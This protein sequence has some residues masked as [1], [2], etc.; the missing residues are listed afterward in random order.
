[1]ALH[2]SRGIIRDNRFFYLSE[3]M[4]SEDQDA[5]LSRGSLTIASAIER[6]ELS[7]RS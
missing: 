3:S 2:F 1:M 5:A 6:L 7:L 4:E